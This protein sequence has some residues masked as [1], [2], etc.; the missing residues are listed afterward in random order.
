MAEMASVQDGPELIL[1]MKAVERLRSLLEESGDTHCKLRIEA[2]GPFDNPEFIFS[3]EESGGT[4]DIE[5]D[6]ARIAVL[7]DPESH[8]RLRGREIDHRHNDNGEHFVV[9]MAG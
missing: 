3:F 7:V 6:Y 4:D 8:R 2:D 9:R 5:L 1:T